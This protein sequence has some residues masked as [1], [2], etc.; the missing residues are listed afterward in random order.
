[1]E[2]PNVKNTIHVNKCVFE[3]YAYKKLSNA[4]VTLALRQ[5]LRNSKRKKL[6]SSGHYKIISIA[7]FDLE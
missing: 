3:I 2:L 5:W 6:P 7:G 1:M 4:E